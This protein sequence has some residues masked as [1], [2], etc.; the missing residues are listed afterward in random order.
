MHLVDVIRKTGVHQ[1]MIW[2]T[3]SAGLER[4]VN[5]NNI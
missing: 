1:L 3:I 2:V 4:D 5:P